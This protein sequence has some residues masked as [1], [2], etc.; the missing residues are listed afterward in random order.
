M[1]FYVRFSVQFDVRIF[2]LGN[3]MKQV[4]FTELRNNAKT[5]FDLVETGESIRI[6]RNGKPVA[7]IVPITQNLPSWKRKSVQPL[8]IDGVSI[9]ELVLQDRDSIPATS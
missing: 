1:H 7:D 9:S 8:V 6:M 5:F 2:K 3:R 4:A